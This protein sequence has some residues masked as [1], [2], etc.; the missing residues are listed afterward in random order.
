MIN[1]NKAFK[2]QIQK[3]N[4]ADIILRD[5]KVLNLE[6]SDF[7][8]GGFSMTDETTTGK[9]GIGSAVGKTISL[10]INNHSNKF[11]SYDFYKSIIYVYVSVTLEDGTILKE[12]KGKYYVINPTSPGDVI[13]ISGVDSMH[14][15]DKPYNSSSAFPT[16]LQIILSECCIKCG[17]N[18]GFGQFDNYDFIVDKKPEDCTYRQVVS[19]V[20]QIAGYNA[21]INNND[22]LELVWYDTE[23]AED[24]LNGGGLFSYDE[25][26][27]YDGGDFTNY[28]DT[29][30]WD[31]GNFT[32]PSP[33][34]VTKI[35]SI[36]VGTDDVVIT[37]VKVKHEETE[38]LEGEEDY[39]ITISDND[40]VAGKEKEI[41]Q[42]LGN[43]LIGIRFRPLSC[44]I[45][46]NPL[47]EPY[48]VAYVY[49]RK[50]NAYFTLINSVS[51][52]V[53]GFTT[54]ACKAEDP[55]RN[56]SSYVSKEA[57]AIVK[58]KK[59]AK[60]NLTN[61]DKAVQNMNMLAANAM[62]LYRE[63]EE[64]EDGSV[65]YYQSNRP[66]YKNEDG[67][68]E[69]VINSVV[70][71]MAAEGFFVSTDGG[72]SYTSG[73]DAN[74][75]AVVNVLSAIGITFDWAKGGTLSLGG[76][77]NLNGVI[78]I[79][80]KTGE[81]TGAIDNNGIALYSKNGTQIILSPLTGLVQR[82]SEGNEFYGLI[83]DNIIE[84][85][86]YDEKQYFLTYYPTDNDVY[87]V[88]YEEKEEK[89]WYV[90][91]SEFMSG[92]QGTK[93]YRRFTYR[94][95]HD[96]AYWRKIISENL[97]SGSEYVEKTIQLPESFKNKKW[98]FRFE[99]VEFDFSN[100]E[101]YNRYYN[102]IYSTDFTKNGI[103]YEGNSATGEWIFHSDVMNGQYGEAYG[104]PETLNK[105][106]SM[107]GV[108]S[109]YITIPEETSGTVT[110]ELTQEYLESIKDKIITEYEYDYS[111]ENATVNVRIKCYC[112]DEGHWYNLNE[113]ARFRI[114]VVC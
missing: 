29:I 105:L 74:G 95:T 102:Y 2:N 68:C 28:T 58:A 5:G 23:K 110:I 41:A 78:K 61:Y 3:V 12:R 8:L 48:D 109:P 75:N 77:D 85:P 92:I 81:N 36:T 34:N 98:V 25:E 22:Y 45:A 11:S 65:I 44:Q 71:K 39:C 16:T 91:P 32:D 87:H 57:Q 46:N 82:D 24:I 114:Y 100:V 14:L 49:D 35:K 10:K 4:Y 70:Y 69:F 101:N 83:Y 93:V 67:K 66:I 30:L 79:Y 108:I 97:N 6:P 86:Q 90:E 55:V 89:Y 18:I 27:I 42:Y 56:E 9:F 72:L 99:Q 111:E 107:P 43:R 51:Y 54:I 73:F 40:L 13:N 19:W 88:S 94:Y 104:D 50:G 103:C 64:L 20:A 62:G 15:F 17:V 96:S 60:E 1:A 21:R 33:E 52:S 63:S 112:S 31:G 37:G 53:S 84:F 80:D 7:I 26:D 47:F 38:V 59:E 113:F 76:F 106:I